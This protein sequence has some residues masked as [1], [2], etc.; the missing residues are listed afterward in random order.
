MRN[1]FILGER[2]IICS[3]ARNLPADDD[4]TFMVNLSA[5]QDGDGEIAHDFL[6]AHP[7]IDV[8]EVGR[9]LQSHKNEVSQWTSYSPDFKTNLETLSWCL[10]TFETGSDRNVSGLVW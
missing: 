3:D 2:C 4:P 1:S 5:C 6:E 7:E 10:L 8:L 9:M